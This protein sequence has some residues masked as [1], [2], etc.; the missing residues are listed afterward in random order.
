MAAPYE[1]LLVQP[2][3]Q[4]RERIGAVSAAI[5]HPEGHVSTHWQPPF[6]KTV[7]GLPLDP[8]NYDKAYASVSPDQP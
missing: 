3:D 8:W 2:I 7:G 4:V 1:E 5:A 6:T